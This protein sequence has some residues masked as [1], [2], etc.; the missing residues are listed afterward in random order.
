MYWQRA[1][2]FANEIAGSAATIVDRKGAGPKNQFDCCKAIDF[3][4]RHG[5]SVALR[6]GLDGVREYVRQLLPLIT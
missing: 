4:E 6:R 2:E 1:A 3:F 5:N